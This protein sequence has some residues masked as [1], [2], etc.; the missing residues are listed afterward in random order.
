MAPREA[1][2]LAQG[3]PEVLGVA[4]AMPTRLIEPRDVGGVGPDAVE[5]GAAWGVSAVGAV[6]SPFGGVGVKV[7]VLDTGIDA[8]H[9]AFSGVELTQRN[10]VD[11][12]STTR[13]METDTAPIAPARS[14]AATW[15][16]CASGSRPA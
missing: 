14:S 5:D 16:A 15:T 13:P 7:A 12:A 9:P 4:R 10:F 8:D 11:V 1:Q 6:A 2:R 3:D